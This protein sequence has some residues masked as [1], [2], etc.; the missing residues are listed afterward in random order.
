M[1]AGCFD[2][3]G[4]EA[5]KS[6]VGVREAPHHA[7]RVLHHAHLRGPRPDFTQQ[8]FPAEQLRA[9]AGFDVGRGEHRFAAR[10]CEGFDQRV[11][12]GEVGCGREFEIERDRAR[13]GAPQ[14]VDHACVV[15]AWQG[16]CLALAEARRFVQRREVDAN[17]HDLARAHVAVADR[18]ARVHR[19]QLAAP[20]QVGRVGRHAEPDRDGADREQ[21]RG[22]T[23]RA[24]YLHRH[25]R[26]NG[27]SRRPAPHR[28]RFDIAS[29]PV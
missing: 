22:L 6:A 12:V 11:V 27:R 16:K 14:R 2:G 13:P 3:R 1:S 7:V 9:P 19:L 20:Q 28:S 8:A 5:V 26:A 10:A 29:C 17:D 21:Q 23:P 25:P 4:R 15:A 24:A 18:V